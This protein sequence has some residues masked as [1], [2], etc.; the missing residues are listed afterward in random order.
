MS[1]EAEKKKL[2]T[3]KHMAHGTGSTSPQSI[4]KGL[5]SGVLHEELPGR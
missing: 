2:G 4:C 3:F 5:K 1:K